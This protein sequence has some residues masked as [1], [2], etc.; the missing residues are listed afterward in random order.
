MLKRQGI[1]DAHTR[2]TVGLAVD[3]ASGT[4][5][6]LSLLS[7]SPIAGINAITSYAFYRGE[8]RANPDFRT[9]LE[10]TQGKG[11]KNG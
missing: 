5:P 4:S 10:Q 6:F 7:T 1:I 3:D 9:K 11:I 8:T 2:A